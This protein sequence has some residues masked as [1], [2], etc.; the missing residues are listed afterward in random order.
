MI[1]S[2]MK[3]YPNPASN[4]ITVEWPSTWVGSAQ[5]ELTE[6][7]GRVISRIHSSQELEHIDVQDLAPGYYLIRVNSP[8]GQGASRIMVE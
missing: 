5:L 2:Q 6:L 3:I 8:Q 4:Y 7:S 1:V